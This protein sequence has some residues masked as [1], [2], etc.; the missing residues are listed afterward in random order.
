MGALNGICG[1]L[2]DT[3]GSGLMTLWRFRSRLKSS[4]GSS[5]YTQGALMLDGIRAVALGF[6]G[7]SGQCPVA[8]HIATGA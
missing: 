8:V 6:I 7:I 3:L 4:I 1:H 2:L 5:G